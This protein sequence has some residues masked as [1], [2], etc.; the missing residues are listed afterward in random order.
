[1]GGGVFGKSPGY[2]HLA[3]IGSCIAPPCVAFESA[4]MALYSS[5]KP[6]IIIPKSSPS[7]LTT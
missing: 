6:Q 1:M 3:E 5:P 2:S 7:T 4:Y